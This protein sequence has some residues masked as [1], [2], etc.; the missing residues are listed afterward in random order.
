LG[1]LG[2]PETYRHKIEVLD[3]WCAKIGRNPTEIDRTVMINNER[4]DDVDEYL[5]AGATHVILGVDAPF[6]LAPLK[7]L[8]E[9]SRG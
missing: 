5:K 3:E 4:I 6:D 1:V 7:R 9:L 8:L 2:D